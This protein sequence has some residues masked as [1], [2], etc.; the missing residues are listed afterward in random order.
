MA[1]WPDRCRSVL[2][3]GTEH[4]HCLGNHEVV[5]LQFGFVPTPQSSSRVREVNQHEEGRVQPSGKVRAF[6]H[7]ERAG[8]QQFAMP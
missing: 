2:M 8:L 6:L 3:G 5:L 1:S 7:G 4:P